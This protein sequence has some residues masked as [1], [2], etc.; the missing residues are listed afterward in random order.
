MGVG[1]LPRGRKKFFQGIFDGTR[2][3]G[4]EVGEVHPADEIKKR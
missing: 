2:Q 1:A 3:K 4:A